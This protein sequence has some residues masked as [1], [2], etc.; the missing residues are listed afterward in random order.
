MNQNQQG[1]TLK[2]YVT[3]RKDYET[4]IDYKRLT[5]MIESIFSKFKLNKR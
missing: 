5:L 1:P 2:L 3:M 4:D